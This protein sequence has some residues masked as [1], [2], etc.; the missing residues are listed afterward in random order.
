MFSSD[1]IL[2]PPLS[3]LFGPTFHMVNV[4]LRVFGRLWLELVPYACDRF[5]LAVLAFAGT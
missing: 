1:E 3:Y 2:P 4:P 5:V